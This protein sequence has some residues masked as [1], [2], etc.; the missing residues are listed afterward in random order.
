MPPHSSANFEIQRYYQRELKL[1]DA[2][3]TNNVPEIKDGVYVM[4]LDKYQLIG[5]HWKAL[6]VNGKRILQCNI[7]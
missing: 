2:Y 3:S 1:N 7:S 4:N 6:Y 5:T